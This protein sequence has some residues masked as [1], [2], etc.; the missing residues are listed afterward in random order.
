MSINSKFI[1]PFK[2]KFGSEVTG[3]YA[4]ELHSKY[5][6]NTEISNYH[7]DTIYID[8]EENVYTAIL[9]SPFTE[10][11]VGGRQY[12]HINYNT[13]SDSSENRPEGFH[14]DLQPQSIRLY[15]HAFRNSPP[16]YWTRDG[17]TKRPVNISI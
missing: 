14:I 3:G 8:N 17:R 10:R 11:W 13:G 9:Q 1:L 5:Y 4:D 6:P 2:V 15:S 12:R 16:A 7:E